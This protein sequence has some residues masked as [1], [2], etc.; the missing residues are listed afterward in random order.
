[1]DV[2]YKL[3]PN[4]IYGFHILPKKS[5]VY[6]FKTRSEDFE[7][8]TIQLMG[9]T[10]AQYNV[11]INREI[12]SSSKSY[13][14]ESAW[15]NG[16]SYD[17]YKDSEEYCT[18]CTFFILVKALEQNAVFRILLTY[19]GKALLM[20]KKS[21]LFDIIKSNKNMCY[22]YPM[23]NFPA[24]DSLIMNFFLFGGSMIAKIN[25]FDNNTN[26]PY[27]EIINSKDTY[28]IIGDRVL[29]FSHE[30]IEEFKNKSI[31][32][33]FKYFHFCLYS[34]QKSSYLLGLHY[35]SY[36]QFMQGLNYL[37]IGQ[38]IKDYLPLNQ[39]TKYKLFDV[40]T[41]SNIKIS[42]EVLQGKPK[43]Y[44]MFETFP[45]IINKNL[46]A[47]YKYMGL[48]L[49]PNA[50]GDKQSIFIPNE[51]N[52]C[53]QRSILSSKPGVVNKKPCVTNIIIECP[54]VQGMDQND[55][56]NDCIYKLSSIADKSKQPIKQKTT[57][58]GLLGKDDY[59]DFLFTIDDADVVKFTIVLNT[60]SGELKLSLYKIDGGEENK[61]LLTEKIIEI[62]S[63]K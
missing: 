26:V 39:V 20:N 38:S 30:Q 4:T 27:S 2:S 60:V 28:E 54:V 21:S 37:N 31:G 11:Y 35:S 48:I 56:K 59:N 6:E 50:F 1:M 34:K 3:S 15:S 63:P 18:N 12:Q 43:L 52:K 8:L 10:S 44:F 14:L 46:L 33:N 19:R 61:V 36:T 47:Q 16:Y 22:Y 29:I 62:F 13:A 51:K 40:G 7:H 24:K 41:E 9:I 17:L 42:L 57:Y 25:G 45:F 23:D 55:I 53:H 5:M 32:K 49:Q 58:R